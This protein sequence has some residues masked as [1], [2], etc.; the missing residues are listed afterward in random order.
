MNTTDQNT[1]PAVEQAA[2]QTP[3]EETA[4][5]QA[6]SQTDINNNPQNPDEETTSAPTFL[7]YIRTGFWD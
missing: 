6:P 7:S 2:A 5:A 3:D 1:A 4:Q